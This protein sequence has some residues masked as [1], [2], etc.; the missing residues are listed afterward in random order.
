VGFAS[1]VGLICWVALFSLGGLTSIAY[2]GLLGCLGFFALNFFV[3]Y[4]LNQARKHQND[5]DDRLT[6]ARMDEAR[7]FLW[8]EVKDKIVET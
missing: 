2:F 6:Q 4:L 7:D 3:A 1:T 8:P 5:Y